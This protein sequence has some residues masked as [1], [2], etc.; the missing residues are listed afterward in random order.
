MNFKKQENL[1]EFIQFQKS[2]LKKYKNYIHNQI[3]TNYKKAALLVYWLNDYINYI[4]SEETFKPNQNITYKKGQIVLVNFG[5]RIG[6]E[7]GGLHYAIV[8]DVKNSPYAS[9]V[10]IVPLRSNKNKKTTYQRIYTVLL[11][12][13]IKSSLYAKATSIAEANF[14]R[15]IDIAHLLNNSP[16]SIEEKNLKKEGLLLKRRSTLAQNILEFSN[17]LKN[18]SIADIGQIT[19]ISKQRIIQPC[20]KDDILTDIIINSEDMQLIEDKI[21]H[22]YFSP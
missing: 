9:N 11:S 13:N 8:L 1:L 17:K 4:K 18:G 10:T 3:K 7:I 20:K 12:S 2:V 5:F 6:K 19:T 22:L 14:K 15:L 21:K 16:T